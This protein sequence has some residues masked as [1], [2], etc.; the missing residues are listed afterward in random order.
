VKAYALTVPATDGTLATTTDIANAATDWEN[1]HL[2]L[3]G[4][5]MDGEIVLAQGDGN[6]IQLGPNGRINATYGE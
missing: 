3:S 2:P 1:T 6:G 4:G 5:T